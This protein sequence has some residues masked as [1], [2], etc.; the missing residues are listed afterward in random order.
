MAAPT[1]KA[2][3]VA[4]EIPAN[5]PV[6]YQDGQHPNTPVLWLVAMLDID[7]CLFSYLYDG[8]SSTP[9]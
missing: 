4:G 9:K 1:D 2:G 6:S 5:W 7:S 3:L 8:H